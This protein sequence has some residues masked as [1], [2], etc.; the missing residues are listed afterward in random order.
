MRCFIF[1]LLS[2]LMAGCAG[3]LQNNSGTAQKSSTFREP[4]QEYTIPGIFLPISEFD[5][6]TNPVSLWPMVRTLEK[7]YQLDNKFS[8]FIE[9]NSFQQISNLAGRKD[10]AGLRVYQLDNC[11]AMDAAVLIA[12]EIP[13]LLETTFNKNNFGVQ[14]FERFYHYKMISSRQN[15]GEAALSND[16][17]AIY[18]EFNVDVPGRF[19]RPMSKAKLDMINHALSPD[20]LTRDER[21]SFNETYKSGLTR[22]TTGDMDMK[23]ATSVSAELTL[24]HLYLLVPASWDEK[25]LASLFDAGLGGLDFSY[26]PPSIKRIF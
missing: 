16:K 17:T 3:A 24:D 1:A 19:I 5:L 4:P 22:N 25:K 2:F 21:K 9:K 20:L 11:Q 13:I 14:S 18:L 26:K 8:Q 15:V 7:K 6:K 10:S 12:N 23:I